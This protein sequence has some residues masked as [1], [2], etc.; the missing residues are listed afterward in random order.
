[1]TVASGC[2]GCC[3]CFI[4]NAIAATDR[5][6]KPVTTR[7]S[8]AK[9][10]A[11]AALRG[12]LS[13]MTDDSSLFARKLRAHRAVT[14]QH[15]R[16][17]QEML[18]QAL[19]VSVDAIG[20]Y[21]RS[22]SF[23][24]GDLESRL[25]ERLGWG[26]DTIRACRE[27]WDDRK[28]GDAHDS[29]YRLLD[30]TLVD[31][32]FAGSYPRALQAMIRMVDGELGALPEEISPNEDIFVPIYD[33]FRNQWCA[34]MS[35]DRIVAKWSVNILIPEDEA[36]FRSGTL[37]ESELSPDR[38]RA[39]ILPGTYFGYCPALVI[40]RGHEAASPLVLS[41]FVAMLEDLARRDVLLHGIGALTCSAAGAQLCRDLNMTRLG[42]HALGPG[43][44]VWELTGQAIANSVF[45]RRSAL[46]ARAYGQAFG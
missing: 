16:M 14:G 42:E 33:A 8:P 12:I 17:T 41:S 39:P 7:N 23:I 27:D 22:V 18:A 24:R 13:A 6:R 34:V 45:A 21:E 2:C 19:G 38:I 5:N 43:F 28:R 20:K 31:R 26:Q 3:N 46:V 37:M 9:L 10:L 29:R 25:A 32:F 44:E 35:D 11:D 15:G 30:D 4:F 36:A 40:V 1:M